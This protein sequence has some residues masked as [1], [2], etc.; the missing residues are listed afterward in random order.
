MR[1][2]KLLFAVGII[3]ISCS[4]NSD[5]ESE[6]TDPIVSKVENRQSIGTSASDFLNNDN[7]DKL[8]I[9]IVHVDTYKPTPGSIDRFRQWLETFT[10]KTD[11]QITYK[12]VASTNIESMNYNK[13]AELENEYRTVYNDGKTLSLY[14]YFTDAG[15]TLD[16]PSQNRFVLGAVYYNTSMVFFQKSIRLLADK[17]TLPITRADVETA[18]IQ[19]EFGHLFGL[20]N[21]GSEREGADHSAPE[22]ENHCNKENCLMVAELNF[23]TDMMNIMSSRT[24]MGLEPVPSL[25]PECQLDLK[26]L[27]GR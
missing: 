16:V 14:M 13:I 25:G 5:N 19:H 8:H 7:F 10:F 4:K 22:D 1:N 21:L 23:N 11:I 6:T 12:S 3:L 18:V 24:A 2:L 17:T 15:S 20:V 27:G 9:E 26:S